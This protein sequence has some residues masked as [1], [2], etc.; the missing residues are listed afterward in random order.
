MWEKNV[1]MEVLNESNVHL[2]FQGIQTTNEPDLANFFNYLVHASNELYP[3]MAW[4]GAKKFY[5]CIIESAA[6][7]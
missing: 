1:A 4:E 5:Q 7:I 3:P 6:L 2:D